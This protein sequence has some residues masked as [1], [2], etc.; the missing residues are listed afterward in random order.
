MEAWSEIRALFERCVDL[1]PEARRPLLAA[2]K[3]EV[4]SEVAD[5]LDVHDAG[6][7]LFQEGDGGRGLRDLADLRPRVGQRIAGFRLL[8]E[9]G[10]GGTG[11][12]YRSEQLEPRRP[13]AL[14]VLSTAFIGPRSRQRFQLEIQLLARLN[15]EGITRIYASGFADLPSGLGVVQVPYYV[16]EYIEDAQTL[17]EWRRKTNP[18]TREVLRVL[19]D[20]ARAVQYAHENGVI[21]QD[22]K[23]QNVLIDAQGAVKLIDFGSARLAN[24]SDSSN[25]RQSYRVGTP[26]YM[27]P[28]QFDAHAE[29]DTRVDVHALGL[30]ALEL[31]SGQPPQGQLEGD[32]LSIAAQIRSRPVPRLRELLPS[33]SS[34]LEA[35]LSKA[36]SFEPASRYGSAGGFADDLLRY[37]NGEA[38]EAFGG[39]LPYQ[40]RVI[41]RCH[42]FAAGLVAALFA[43]VS[44]LAF[45]AWFNTARA[46]EAEREL[47]ELTRQQREGALRGLDRATRL[48]A[49][50]PTEQ[51]YVAQTPEA[52]KGFWLNAASLS[53]IALDE[54]N[55]E[56]GPVAMAFA[57]AYAKLESKRREI[58]DTEWVAAVP[59]D[60]ADRARS[61]L[62]DYIEHQR[63]IGREELLGQLAFELGLDADRPTARL[64][65]LVVLRSAMGADAGASDQ[66]EA[67]RLDIL[68]V[69]GEREVQRGNLEAALA[70]Y[71]EELARQHSSLPLFVDDP[72][73]PAALMAL[74]RRTAS[75]EMFE[76][77]S[78]SARALLQEVL[79]LHAS[80]PA[81]LG[82][83]ER[84][85]E[86]AIAGALLGSLLCAEGQVIEGE[87]LLA[88]AEATLRGEAG[89]QLSAQVRALIQLRVADHMLDGALRGMRGREAS[90]HA[91]EAQE[92][93]SSVAASAAAGGLGPFSL[94]T[95]MFEREAVRIR[96]AAIE[97]RG[98]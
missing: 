51:G 58:A 30:T 60:L 5:L 39:G 19:I 41:V 62:E 9:L 49:L 25:G 73:Y 95:L 10:R 6:E 57:R 24:D 70:S 45:Y 93:A 88:A 40:L 53:L 64:L 76:G 1:A 29:A 2:A 63:S 28:E 37:L 4:Q 89:A 54:T 84:D 97:F 21:H 34:E 75:I 87:K 90:Q 98:M 86:V 59:A 66:R 22:L 91:E 44:I 81:R 26:A 12:V 35:I 52:Q 71:R 85:R 92:I 74:R 48:L 68:M 13:V 80:A 16:R 15:H 43:T 23:P 17:D 46:L 79:D 27:A 67:V 56:K 94:L 77:R 61:H 65:A 55:P 96:E 31:L 38:V 82:S 72:T 7:G 36:T 8:E 83:P 3:P 69:S 14:K 20:V 78:E 42:R 50:L 11:T 47:T 18:S 33:A 32:M